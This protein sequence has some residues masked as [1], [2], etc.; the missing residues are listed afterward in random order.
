MGQAGSIK[1]GRMP[2]NDLTGAAGPTRRSPAQTRR[3]SGLAMA[4]GVLPRSAEQGPAGRG[5][6]H[7]HGPNFVTLW[8]IVSSLWTVA[9]GLRILRVWVPEAGWPAVMSSAFTWAGLLV[10]PL[11]FAVILVAMSRV[12]AG[13]HG[14]G[15]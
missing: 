3:A 11:V 14:S 2:E 9:T 4:S 6:S 15:H 13:H 10:P 1:S 7:A 5:R 8:I 12:A